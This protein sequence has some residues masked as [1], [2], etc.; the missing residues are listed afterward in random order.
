MLVV[1]T[2]GQERKWV[3]LRI[4]SAFLHVGGLCYSVFCFSDKHLD[5]QFLRRKSCLV[6]KVSICSCL[7]LLL[8]ACGEGAWC[9]G[10]TV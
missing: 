4:M 6:P 8:W 5:N 7:V 9:G 1:L 2:G 10:R 3:E